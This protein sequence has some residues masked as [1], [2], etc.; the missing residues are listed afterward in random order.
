MQYITDEHLNYQPCDEDIFIS[1]K[2][3]DYQRMIWGQPL[4]LREREQK[5]WQAFEQYIKDHSLE[6]LPE[7]YVTE[8]TRMGFRF[9]QGVGWKYQEAY[10]AIWANHKFW[11]ERTE[12]DRAQFE[13]FLQSGACY[14][15][16]RAKRGH[17][18]VIVL[19]IKKFVS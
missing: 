15:A 7:A 9:L 13:E 17:Q 12:M 10:D 16:G 18:P 1:S 2:S 5:H 8:E 4:E 3:G 19:N 6:P 14:V 11:Q